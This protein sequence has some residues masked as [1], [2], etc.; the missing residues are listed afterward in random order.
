MKKLKILLLLLIFIFSSGC[1]KQNQSNFRS[2]FEKQIQKKKESSKIYDQYSK[3]IDLYLENKEHGE[4]IAVINK[5]GQSFSWLEN[6][7]AT[8]K[9]I[10]ALESILKTIPAKE[11]SYNRNLYLKLLFF[12][13]DNDKYLTKYKHYASKEIQSRKPF[14]YFSIKDIQFYK[15]NTEYQYDIFQGVNRIYIENDDAYKIEPVSADLS[16]TREQDKNNPTFYVMAETKQGQVFN[17]FFTRKD[18]N[19]SNFA[20]QNV[21]SISES[22]AFRLCERYIKANTTNPSTVK[23][24]RFWDKSFQTF[25]NGKAKLLTSFKAKNGYGLELEYDIVCYYEGNKLTEAEIY[26]K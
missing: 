7:N 5:Y 25:P 8:E 13:Q 6:K 23:I 14:R 15:N 18:A 4:L 21:A 11:T 9:T 22:Q 2:K 24:S 20:L 1:L 10:L 3:S 17:V 19:S 12:D 26:Q 16:T